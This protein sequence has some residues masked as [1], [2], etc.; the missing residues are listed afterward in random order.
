MKIVDTL[1]DLAG[2][3]VVADRY[4]CS[5]KPEVIVNYW[6]TGLSTRDFVRNYAYELPIELHNNGIGQG[7]YSIIRGIG[8]TPITVR[9]VNGSKTQ[10]VKQ[11]IVPIAC[12]KVRAGI[13]TRFRNSRWEKYLKSQGWVSA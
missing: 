13:A 10:C 6:P 2:D 1:E 12:P 9:L 11:D 3:L 8:L 7:S 4:L 5:D